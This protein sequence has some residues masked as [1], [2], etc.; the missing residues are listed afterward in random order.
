MRISDWSSDV[1]SSDLNAEG[2][3]VG[4]LCNQGLHLGDGHA[5]RLRHSRHLALGIVRRNLRIEAAARG[6]RKSVVLGKSVSVRVGI[7]G[8]LISKKKIIIYPC[9]ISN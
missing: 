5:A 2:R 9:C 4:M 1:C 3:A 6:D 8:R 7:G